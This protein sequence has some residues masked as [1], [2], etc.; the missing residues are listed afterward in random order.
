MT[1]ALAP[2]FYA[3][4]ARAEQWRSYLTRNVLPGAPA[5]FGGVGEQLQ[6]AAQHHEATTDIAYPLAVV[7]SE[8]GNRLEVG[9]EPAGQPHQLHVPL[10][11]PFQPA[12]GLDPVEVAIDEEPQ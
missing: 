3:D 7:A 9:R 2:R 6:V 10:A 8:V 12:A 5:D 4:G 11:F 1:A